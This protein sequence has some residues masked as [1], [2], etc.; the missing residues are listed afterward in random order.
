MGTT[1]T[2]TNLQMESSLKSEI[3]KAT[4]LVSNRTQ[5]RGYTIT[6]LIND[7]LAI[8]LAFWL[9]RLFIFLWASYQIFTSIS[10]L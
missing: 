4:H 1:P 6:L 5:W 10:I 7:F 9:A 3:Y 8:S 2:S